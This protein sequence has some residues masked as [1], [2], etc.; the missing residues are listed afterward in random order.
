M[1]LID[2]YIEHMREKPGKLKGGPTSTTEYN[3]LNKYIDIK[4]KIVGF[5]I[6]S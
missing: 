3:G 1:S 4:T 2:G 5:L 6:N